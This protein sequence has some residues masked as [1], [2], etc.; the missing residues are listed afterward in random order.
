MTSLTS[1]FSPPGK[2]IPLEW[3]F[4]FMPTFF[5]SGMCSQDT[6]HLLAKLRT[7]L[8]TPSNLIVMGD[9]VA[10]CGHLQHVLKSFQKS[11]HGLILQILENKDKQNYK[12]IECLLSDDVKK[13]LLEIDTTM[14][15]QGTIAYLDMMRNIRDAFLDRGI[16][17]LK[18]VYLMWE[19]IF[20]FRIWR[21][22]LCTNNHST[23]DHFVTQNVYVCTELNEHT[24]LNI[25]YNVIQD[26]YPVST[27]R[28]DACDSQGCEEAFRLLR[29]MT[30]TFSTVINFSMKGVLERAHKLYFLVSIKASEDIV[31]PR[32]Q[33]RLL[34]IQKE[35]EGTL[36]VPSLQELTNSV[37]V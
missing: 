4:F 7:R 17:P 28:V 23:S 29:S 8:L 16:T 24:I 18:R 36:E 21:K 32:T 13:S 25:I 31:V 27:L 35:S 37:K 19:T 33:R 30:Q 14:K 10:C 15:T 26:R 22:W 20:F 34:Q 6:V 5:E 11:K 12:S 1:L 3:T 2:T 9:E